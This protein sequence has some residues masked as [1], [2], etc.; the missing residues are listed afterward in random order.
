MSTQSDVRA[1]HEKFGHYVADEPSLPPK[2]VIE[3][4]KKMIMEEAKELCEALDRGDIVH[5]AQEIADLHY[6]TSGASVVCGIDEQ[7][8]HE[9]VQ[10][11]NM[12]KQTNPDGGKPLKPEGWL[13][14]KGLIAVEIMRQQGGIY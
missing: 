7:K 13:D 3:F 5:I 8:V 11:A 10:R 4:R 12:A 9:I 6:V 2:A 1:F 14:P